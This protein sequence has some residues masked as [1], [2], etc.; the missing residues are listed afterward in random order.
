VIFSSYVKEPYSTNRF[1]QWDFNNDGT[2]DAE[3]INLTSTNAV[4]GLGSHSV[5]ITISNG[6]GA[7]YTRTRENYLNVIPP[8]ECNF[9]ASTLTADA[10]FMVYFTDLSTNQ[11]QY[12]KWDFNGDGMIDSFL[13]NPSHIYSS[14]GSFNVSLTVS[15]NF[16]L[17][18]ASTSTETK[19]SYIIVPE[20]ADSSVHYVSK[21]GSHLFPFKSWK[22]AATN[23]QDAV[24]SAASDELI[25]V[26]NGIY[27]SENSIVFT[28]IIVRSINGAE[29]TIIQGTYSQGCVKMVGTNALLEGFT[30]QRGANVHGS[31]VHLLLGASIKNCIINDNHSGMYT[32]GGIY[33]SYLSGFVDNCLIISNSGSQGAGIYIGTD[34]IAQNCIIKYNSAGDYSTAVFIKNSKLINSLVSKNITKGDM[35][36]IRDGGIIENCTITD[37][38]F[39]DSFDT[40]E[41]Y[42]S[43]YVYNSIFYGNS[44]ASFNNRDTGVTYWNSCFD[45]LP[46]AVYRGGGNIALNPMFISPD[47]DNYYMKALSP[48]INSGSNYFV[49]VTNDIYGRLRIIDGNVDMGCIENNVSFSM[50]PPEIISPTN[51][52][53]GESGFIVFDSPE[54]NIIIEGYKNSNSYV[55]L[56]DNFQ[57]TDVDVYQDSSAASWSNII[58]NVQE[59]NYILKFKSMNSNF[60]NASIDYTELTIE[61]IPEPMGIIFSM[62][63][64]CALLRR[65]I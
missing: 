34:Y 19:N 29:N 37:N 62:I 25:L 9:S 32:G 3:G 7:A 1:Y 40:L 22:E 53:S 21:S 64:L 14:T 4:Y 28:N 5:S 54:Q 44:S 46:D 17:G 38:T 23:I 31:G 57:W 42:L 58:Y 2:F 60:T 49:S 18:G 39:P 35:V 61:V 47:N 13:Q 51:I 27:E 26:T 20:I 63:A 59:T 11:P 48:C 15:N 65:D 16:G 33:C 41:I 55:Y 36:F 24:L 6:L 50:I 8:V 56:E 10:P 52:F 12:W 30:V 45:V 43:G